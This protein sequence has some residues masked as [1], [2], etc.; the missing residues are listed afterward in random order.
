MIVISIVS[1]D[2]YYFGILSAEQVRSNI[3]RSTGH[4]SNVGGDFLGTKLAPPIVA[5]NTV[6][7]VFLDWALIHKEKL[8]YRKRDQNQTRRSRTALATT[9]E[10]VCTCNFS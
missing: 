10:R 7:T 3:F 8:D 6:Y 2:R 4:W 1:R 9:P 5:I